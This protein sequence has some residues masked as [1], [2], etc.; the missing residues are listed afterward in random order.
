MQLL[1]HLARI[2]LGT[3]F[4]YSALLK[5]I[6]YDQA[7]RN[8][9]RYR[10]MSE[11]TSNI[12][13]II[14]PWAE[15]FAGISLFLGKFYPVGPLIGALLGS[16]FTYTAHNILQRK[17]TVPCG[18]T[19]LTDTRVDQTTRV[20]GFAITMCSIL[21]FAVGKQHYIRPRT[22]LVLAGFSLAI[23]PSILALHHRL[24]IARQRR[25]EIQQ[26]KERLERLKYI[27]AHP[28]GELQWR[29]QPSNNSSKSDWLENV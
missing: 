29:L 13:G 2:W 14:L 7:R 27:L 25:Q 26:R 20:R 6:Y 21:V 15:L 8:I 10:L 3:L 19:G 9:K 11:Q 22:P 17:R 5:F 18:C 1:S 28:Q 12:V 24:Q 16:S 4:L 23:L